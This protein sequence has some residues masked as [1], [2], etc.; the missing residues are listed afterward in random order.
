MIAGKYNINVV[1]PMGSSPAEFNYIEDGNTLSGSIAM[2][3]T[4]VDFDGGTINGNDFS[5]DLH[6]DV[7]MGKM[8]ATIVGTV[9]G[10][11]IKGDIKLSVGGKMPFSGKRA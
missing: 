6:I 4:S 3:G 7:P 5:H 9:D 8:D 11:D 10:D 2:M 1:S